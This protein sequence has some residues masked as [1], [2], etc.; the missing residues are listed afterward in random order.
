MGPRTAVVPVNM[1]NVQTNTVGEDRFSPGV[2]CRVPLDRQDYVDMTYGEHL[3]LMEV[4]S[5]SSEDCGCGP[6]GD[7]DFYDP[8]VMRQSG[9][10]V[11][12]RRPRLLVCSGRA[13]R[14]RG[15]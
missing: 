9:N 7:F 15:R 5:D 10:G 14:G 1:V 11:A 4:D 2:G 12:P 3:E 13:L 8:R 6:L